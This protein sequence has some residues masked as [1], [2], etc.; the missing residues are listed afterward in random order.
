MADEGGGR[1]TLPKDVKIVIGNANKFFQGEARAGKR[2][3]VTQIVKRTAKAT[4]LSE[5]TVERIRAEE[6]G[7]PFCEHGPSSE[8]HHENP[9]K[10]CI[11][12]DDFTMSAIRLQVLL[13]GVETASH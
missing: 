10:P 6:A 13:P 11:I 5:R 7:R 1:I 4:E 3:L 9:G 2:K 8:H 12:I